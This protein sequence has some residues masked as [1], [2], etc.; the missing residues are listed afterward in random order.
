MFKVRRKQRTH[1]RTNAESPGD[2]PPPAP[3]PPRPP[4][5]HTLTTRPHTLTT[6]TH[7]LTTRTHTHTHT[8]T[9][10]PRLGRPLSV[11]RLKELAGAEGYRFASRRKQASKQGMYHF[12]GKK[13]AS[14]WGAREGEREGE[15][16]TRG[17][18]EGE[19]EVMD[20]LQSKPILDVYRRDIQHRAAEREPKRAPLFRFDRLLS[21][22][23]PAY[24]TW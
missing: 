24:G 7:T 8:H 22:D 6:R 9:G 23:A 13:W 19:C 14:C 12:R 11:L 15:H 10:G 18:C 4:A 3:P 21:T 20:A 5:P 2:F 17:A 1:T 16:G